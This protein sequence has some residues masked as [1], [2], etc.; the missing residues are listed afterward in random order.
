VKRIPTAILVLV[1][2]TA[3][4]Q[5]KQA[6]HTVAPTTTRTRA[7]TPS[8]RHTS[9]SPETSEPDST[10]HSTYSPDQLQTALL[11][12]GDLPTGFTIDAAPGDPSRICAMPA[13]SPVSAAT[14]ASVAFRGAGARRV[15]EEID[16]FPGTG[17]AYVDKVRDETSCSSYR[18]TTVTAIPPAQIA[19]GIDTRNDAVGIGV[20]VTPATAGST[21]IIWIRQGDLVIKVRNTGTNVSVAASIALAQ[22]CLSRMKNTLA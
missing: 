12:T 5:H 6:E 17:D 18:G 20:R 2:A 16:D 7:S 11:G 14:G 1:V 22:R 19:G 21:D 4:A 13:M 3:C 9:V 15:S 10:G 8:A